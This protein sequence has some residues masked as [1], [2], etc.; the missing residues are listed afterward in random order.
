MVDLKQGEM[1]VVRELRDFDI[2]SG[3]LLER[4]VFNHRAL[5]IALIAL[6]TL[7]LGYMAVTRLEMR[8]AFEKMIPHG[9]PYIRNYLDNR[10]A[11]RGLGNSVRVVVENPG[12]DIFDPAYIDSL[13]HISA[14]ASLRLLAGD[15]Q[16]RHAVHK[17]VKHTVQHL[18]RAR[19]RVCDDGRRSTGHFRIR[20]RHERGRTLVAAHYKARVT[21]RPQRFQ[22]R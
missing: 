7:V 19:P 4:L 20:G 13:R 16:Q 3:N 21:R 17:R 9:D 15:D 2:H 8:P 5:F 22:K 1:P 10:A 11:L 6:V 14:I 12:G 18:H